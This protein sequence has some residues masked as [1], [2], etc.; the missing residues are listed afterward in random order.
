MTIAHDLRPDPTPDRAADPA[1]DISVPV[2]AAAAPD[3][4]DV[5]LPRFPGAPIDDPGDR[6]LEL[7]MLFGVDLDDLQHAHGRT[8]GADPPAQA[9]LPL[10]A[11][12]VVFITGPSGGGKT[13]FL[14]A[15]EAAARRA[16]RAVLHQDE[17][18][19]PDVHRPLID[20]FPDLDVETAAR[21][22]AHA[23]LSE[24]PLLFRPVGGLSDGQHARMRLAQLLDA[25]ARLD[26][27]I[28]F[29]DEFGAALDR[30]TAA[31]LAST[32]ASNIRRE[33]RA[34]IV[35]ATA[36]DDLL[37]ALAPDVLV[38]VHADGALEI[39]TREETVDSL[40]APRRAAS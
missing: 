28:L 4:I 21:R 13:T 3:F 34:T 14:H 9:R 2:T 11:G 38:Y 36:H 25:G 35:L 26:D 23:G 1:P 5:P 37:P 16:G 19:P 22:L 20:V 15:A 10:P 8:D 30:V 6:L 7:A 33:R 29:A 40:E 24:V 27:P 32:L 39:A 31:S 12:G 18:D 17:L